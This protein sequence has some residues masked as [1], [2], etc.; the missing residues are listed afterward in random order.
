MLRRI[1][2]GRR[3]TRLLAVC[4]VVVV[5]GVGAFGLAAFDFADVFAS[6]ILLPD[7][8]GTY[9]AAE[10]V[11]APL[12]SAPPASPGPPRGPPFFV[13]FQ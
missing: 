3:S 6:F 9:V 5:V 10:V 4:L 8:R 13:L 1:R 2:F 12:P 7:L 11:A